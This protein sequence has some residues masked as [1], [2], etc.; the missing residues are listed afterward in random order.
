MRIDLSDETA[1]I[2]AILKNTI[3]GGSFGDAPKPI[4]EGQGTANANP[5][6]PKPNEIEENEKNKKMA[7]DV[8]QQLKRSRPN[9]DW[10]NSMFGRNAGDLVKDLRLARRV[11]KSMSDAIDEAIDAIRIAKKQEVE[12]TLQSIEW[13]GKHDTTVRNLGISDRDLQ[14]L[15]KH[16]ISR[17]YA[18]RRACLQWEKSNDT[19]S[20]LL[21]IE[22]D[23]DDN[24]RQL[25]VDA[26]QV[27]KNAKKEW[28]NSLHSVDNIKKTDAIFLAK[29][30]NILEERGPLS[31]KEVFNSMQGTTHLTTQKLSALFKMHGVEYDIEKIGI[32]WGLVRDNSVIFKDIWAYAAGFLD[33]DGYITITKRLE[34]RAGFIATG[35]R[36]K[37]HCEQLHKALGCG[38]LQT[39]LKIHKNS[40]RTQH[41]LQFYSEKDLR[42][43]MKG[44]TQHLR[45]KKGQAGAVI[46]LLDVRGRKTDIIKSRRDELY[47]IVKWLNWK[48]V[49]DKREELLK[50]W[51]IDEVG[52][53]AMFSR[54]G[55][56]LR[57]LDD[58]TRL[59]E[60]M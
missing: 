33:A 9:G 12:A 40:R 46:E 52:V 42:K 23:F 16:G 47:R 4:Q 11:N 8:A 6:P 36:G 58:A 30:A 20:K 14:A 38:V 55:E 21:L 7:Q 24:Q 3:Q 5:T 27:K 29:A 60:M 15:R 13:I 41:R 34:P 44:I 1:F 28:K 25:W 43:L 10:F 51:N 22:G 39:D 53:R 31:S 49:P 37:L 56:T 32:G 50:E 17:E 2:D 19:I 18:L 48:D 45:M 54:D 59:V 26:Q 57:L 35:E